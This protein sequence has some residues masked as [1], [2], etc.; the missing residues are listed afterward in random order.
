M[1]ASPDSIPARNV[2]FPNAPTYPRGLLGAN[3]SSSIGLKTAHGF[4]SI[5]LKK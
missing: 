4:L 5:P 3:A 2:V 1:H